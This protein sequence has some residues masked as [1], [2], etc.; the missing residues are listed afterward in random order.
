MHTQNNSSKNIEGEII[1]EGSEYLI[2][3]FFWWR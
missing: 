2:Y 1:V 3:V